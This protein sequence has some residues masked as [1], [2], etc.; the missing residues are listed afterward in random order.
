[1]ADDHLT[2]A[3]YNSDL[4]AMIDKLDTELTEARADVRN[5]QRIADEHLKD[6][7]GAN[8]GLLATVDRLRADLERAKAERDEA[9]ETAVQAVKLLE[10]LTAERGQVEEALDSLGREIAKLEN[11]TVIRNES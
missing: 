6:K 10:V 11:A 5:W 7:N 9:R 4:I 3:E 1:M 8:E 2:N